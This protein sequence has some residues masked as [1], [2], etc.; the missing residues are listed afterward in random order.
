[1]SSRGLITSAIYLIFFWVMS[2]GTFAFILPASFW[3]LPEIVVI[4]GY[5]LVCYALLSIAEKIKDFFKMG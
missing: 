4:I 5:V 2:W 3:E 1:M